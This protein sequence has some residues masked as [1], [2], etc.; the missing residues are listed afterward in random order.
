MTLLSLLSFSEE[1]QVLHL[2]RHLLRFPECGAEILEAVPR[3]R[4]V[5]EEHALGIRTGAGGMREHRF[6]GR[7]QIAD[8]AAGGADGGVELA[9]H[10]DAARRA[11]RVLVT[12]EGILE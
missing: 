7:R 10:R 12:R 4:Q 1:L 5:G 11:D 9:T 8:E 6:V 2:V 3:A